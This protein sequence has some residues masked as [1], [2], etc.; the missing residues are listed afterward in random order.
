MRTS[1]L[2]GV[3]ETHRGFTVFFCLV[4]GGSFTGSIG[5]GSFSGLKGVPFMGFTGVP[6]YGFRV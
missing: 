6:F 2:L 1:W 5:R 4:Y 3:R